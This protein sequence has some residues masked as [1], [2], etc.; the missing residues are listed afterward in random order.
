MATYLVGTDGLAASEA[1]CDYLDGRI[2]ETDHLEVVN[3]LKSKRTRDGAEERMAGEEALELF[4]ERFG[5]RT[6]VSTR[7]Y[8]RGRTPTEELLHQADEVDADQLV[9][10]LRRHSRT[11]RIIV[12]SVSDALVR[13]TTRP[14]TLVPLKE[15]Q[16]PVE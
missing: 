9:T 11:E 2:D 3:V 14:I 10:A 7:Q 4:E 13:R 5:G 12:G 16:P 8:H 6:S 1:I 15:Y